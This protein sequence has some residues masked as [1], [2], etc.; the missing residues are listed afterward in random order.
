MSLN[1][2]KR[3][4]NHKENGGFVHTATHVFGGINRAMR[5]ER[6]LQCAETYVV[7]I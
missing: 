6:F 5:R 4:G 2:L 7:E 1:F 3:I